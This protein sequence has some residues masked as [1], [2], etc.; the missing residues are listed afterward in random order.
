MSDFQQTYRQQRQQLRQQLHYHS[1]MQVPRLL[2]VVI[3]S[4][5]KDAVHDKQ[6]VGRVCTQL[7]KICGQKPVITRARR[8]IASFKLRAGM[9]AGVKVTLRGR[10]MFDFLHKL[11]TV[12]LPRVRDF[13]G[14]NPQGF[15]QQGNI[16]YGI[17]DQL[18]FPELGYDDVDRSRGMDISI[19]TSATSP[20]AALALLK[21]IGFPFRT[22]DNK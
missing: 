3:N 17:K 8:S 5:V 6:S 13:R 20:T 11:L 2:K 19:V 7:G 12:Q 4:G 22:D 9:P 14:L 1:I 10:R 15:D 16:T 21:S 18:V